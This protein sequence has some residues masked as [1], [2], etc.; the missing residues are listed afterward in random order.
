LE[1]PWARFS[2]EVRGAWSGSALAGLSATA[3]SYILQGAVETHMPVGPLPSPSVTPHQDTVFLLVV[4]GLVRTFRRND[5]RQVTTR[6][7][8]RCDF[9]GIPSV[10]RHGSSA[11]GEILADAHILR[12]VPSRLREAVRHD[13][14]AAW[15]VMQE[16]ARLHDAA[17][18]MACDNVFLSVRQRVARHLLDLAVR[19]PGGLTVYASHQDIADA[20]G[21]V[22]E[23]VSRVLRELREEALVTR[24]G[25]R[26]V[27]TRPAGLTSNHR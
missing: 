23:V 5:T 7:A 19:E 22:R 2:G 17:V 24:T 3:T 14:A 8:G 13:P 25:D 21:S 1:D 18:D 10:L 4:S 12:M 9:V 15:V 26:L 20:V 6:Y 16:V 11:H 27:L